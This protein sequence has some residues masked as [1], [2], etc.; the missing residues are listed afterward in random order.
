MAE[1]IENFERAIELDPHDDL[2]HFFCAL[3]YALARNLTAAQ[4]R[5]QRTLEINVEN[6][7]ALML[8]ALLFT[9][10]KDYKSALELVIN[11]LSD[12][13]THYGLLVLRLKL[14]SKYGKPVLFLD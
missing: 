5:C 9:A 4:E 8:M 13:P 2:A 6:P 7:S 3:E 11:A 12:F 10:K 14:E 1:S